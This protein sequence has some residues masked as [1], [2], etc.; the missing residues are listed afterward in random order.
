MDLINFVQ[1][2]QGDIKGEVEITSLIFNDKIVKPNFQRDLDISRCEEIVK[3]MNNFF[4]KNSFYK[5]IGT[6]YLAKINDIYYLIDGQHRLHAAQMIYNLTNVDI[7]VDLHIYHCKNLDEVYE[8]FQIL[9]FNKEIPKWM[10]QD[11]KDYVLILKNV[12]NKFENKYG[13]IIVKNDITVQFPKFN[14]SKFLDIS[15][16]Y[17]VF[18]QYTEIQIIEYL[19]NLNKH[20]YISLEKYKSNDNVSTKLNKLISKTKFGM[21]ICYLGTI[22]L[23]GWDK[24][25]RKKYYLNVN[26]DIIF[27]LFTL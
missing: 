8:L 12:M 6:I 10:H 24:F 27:N 5:I 16:K 4:Q 13:D 22:R 11:N 7:Y 19:E 23:S 25:F 15:K 17:N 3:N 21:P 9:N 18:C 26:E 1:N 2:K 20:I 14:I